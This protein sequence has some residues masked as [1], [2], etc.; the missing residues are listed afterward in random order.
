MRRGFDTGYFVKYATGELSEA[1]RQA[2]RD[3]VGDEGL[4]VAN[5]LVIYE[6][7]KLGYR[8]VFDEEDAEWL[9]NIVGDACEMDRVLSNSF[10]DEAARLSH[11]NNLSMADAMML[12]TALR[13]DAD[14]LYTTDSDLLAYEGPIEVVLV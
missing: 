5:A 11:G 14:E 8:G 9:V 1:H 6:L 7:R 10:L 12:A 2:L 13:H 3:L 4:G